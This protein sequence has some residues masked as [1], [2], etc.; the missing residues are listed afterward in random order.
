MKRFLPLTALATLAVILSLAACSGAPKPKVDTHTCP[1]PATTMIPVVNDYHGTEITDNYRWLEDADSDEVQAWT[2]D[3]EAFTHSITDSLP[4]RSW[5]KQ[6]FN[7]L[8]RYDDESIPQPVLG[9]ERLFYWTKKKED[10]KWVYMTKANA[11]AEGRIV[12][13][14]N[15]WEETE[16]LGGLSASRDGKYVAYGVT[17]GGDENP[18]M[19]IMIT[20]TGELL[21]DKLR[22]WKQSV[23]SWLPDN[24]GFYY[25]CRPLEGEVPAGEHEYWHSAWY[26]KLGTE[27]SEDVKVFWDD[28]VKETWHRVW[29]TEDAEY[30]VYSRSLFNATDLFYRK[31]GDKGELIP[32]ATG[33]ENQYGLD[34]V[35]GKMLI[36]TNEDAPRKMVY[37]TTVDKPER[38]NWKVFL[39]E[40]P[41][42]KLSHISAING[43]I[44]A[45]Y[46]HNTYSVVKIYTLE[47][48]F[49]RD[50]PFPTIG[51]G[52]VGGRW[53][54]DDIWVHFS[55]FI[56]PP[57]TFKYDSDT[58]EMVVYHDFPVKV[59]VQGVVADQ[60]W[61]ESKDGTPVSMFIV[62]KDDMKLDGDNPTM[63]YGYGG[64]NV[65]MRPRFSTTALTWLEAGG[66]YVVTNLRGGGEYGR[67]WHEAGMLDKKQNVFDDFIAAAEHLIA[68]GYTRPEKLAI[69]G[70]SNGGLLVG[71]VTVQRP[72]LFKVV[73]CAVPVLDM[74]TYHQHGLAN[75]WAEE[76]GSSDDP[77]Q[78]KYLHAYSP[79]H[80]IR[81]NVKYPAFLV[82]G[83]ENDA[84]V[85]P[86][87]AR[88][89]AAALQ[90]A[91]NGGGPIML[92]INKASGHGGGTTITTQIDQQVEQRAFLMD[93]LGMGVPEQ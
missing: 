44:Y 88:K 19:R 42:D 72:D 34:I 8:W 43:Y 26:H 27:A 64:F 17:H 22:G 14:P 29:L 79:Y 55:S 18:V 6:R 51:S 60:V 25:T 30:T 3:Q 81:Q 40:N 86:L 56:Y 24:E 53:T 28:D 35:E 10:E 89:M 78:F 85:D 4:Q 75:I 54:S 32:L 11:D 74:V 61:Y 47:G 68:N 65:S 66:V 20:E 2:A 41:E 70:G 93:Q 33:M 36:T 83:S 62:H 49:V 45:S 58:N 23:D 80:N 82:T 46:T 5:L 52:G 91:D 69:S 31:T 7:D 13:D 71:A 1:Y 92:L 87:H 57:T 39:P 48:D 76:L 15:E 63:L 50:L 21:P 67:E 73:R 12:L 59:D 38:E 9:G 84:R 90:K 77:E 37:V 16:T